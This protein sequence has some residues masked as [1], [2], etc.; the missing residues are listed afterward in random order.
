MSEQKILGLDL[1]S[2]SIGW[3]VLRASNK[4]PD[5]IIAAGSRIFNKAVEKKPPTLKNV[6]RRNKRL[7][8]RVLQRRARR[9]LKMMRY[10]IK[11]NLLP[12]DIL[13]SQQPEVILNDLGDPYHLR[14][15]GLDKKL[16][17]YE[18]GRVLLHLVQR[19]G[20]LSNR[21]TVLG[22]MIDDP[23]VLEILAGKDDDASNL[24][25]E[26][27][28][29]ETTF[30]A[31]IS[32]LKETIQNANCRT[33]G[34]YLASLSHH[35]SQRNRARDG[36]HLRTDRQM[37][38]E[39]L[40]LIWETQQQY[41]PALDDQV[42]KQ[43]EEII[44]T[45]R[46]LRLR[47]DRVGKCSLEHKNNRARMARLEAQKFRY[48][49]DINNLKFS[50]PQT[51]RERPLSLDDKARL[52]E[53]FETDLKVNL[54]KIKKIIGLGNRLK[55]NLESKNIKPNITAC[56]IR[57][58]LPEWDDFDELKQ[59]AL[60]EDLITF[61]KKSK[62][63]KRLINHWEFDINIATELCLLEFEPGHSNL[64]TKAIKKLLPFLKQGQIYSDARK[65]AGYGYET[66]ELEPTQRLG[67][68]RKTSNPI[69]NKALHE[70]RR[71]INAVIKE[72][73]KPDIIRIEMARDLEMNTKRYKRRISQQN[74]NKK[75]N[76]EAT[77]K[78]QQMA[79]MNPHLGLSHYP[80][81]TDKVRYR[82]WKDQNERCAYSG[83]A[84][85]LSTLFSSGEIEIDHIVPY[86]QSLDD[87]YMNKVVC[88]AREN[89]YKGQ[90]TPFDAFGGDEEK[91][92]QL[93]QA[94]E[95]WDERAL[96]SKKRRFYLTNED[97]LERDF[98]SSQ[99]NDTRY[100]SRR[101]L[102]YVSQLGADVNVTKG[103][104]VSQ[105]RWQWGL[106]SLI[107]KTHEKERTDHRHHA[108]DAIVIACVDRNFHK[109][110]TR[111]AR[112]AEK[113]ASELKVRDIPIPKPWK[114]LKQDAQKVIESI[115]VSHSP[116]RKITGG[117]H[118][119]TG[120]GFIEKLG[121]T[122]YR[123][124]LNGD[125]SSG[126]AKKIVDEN[127][128]EIITRHLAKYANDPK[129]A[130]AE[131]ITVFHKDGKTPIKRVRIVQ[132]KT[133]LKKL[134][135]SK[136]GVKNKRGEVFK[137]MAYGNIHHVEIIRNKLTGK[138]RGEFVTAME[139]SKRAKGIG[140]PKQNIVK[141]DHG[142]NFEFLMV[143]HT[144]DL[145]EINTNGGKQ[146]YRVQKISPGTNMVSF[147]LHTAANDNKL[148]G[149]DITV[150]NDFFDKRKISKLNLNAIGIKV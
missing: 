143:L 106:N 42:K 60:A 61:T 114:Q 107:G 29:E 72:Y 57:Q 103:I 24:S 80:S 85:N 15:K 87:S 147:R 30:K 12:E 150:N 109:Q 141:T 98:A 19:R 112:E 148:E 81:Q 132:S 117:L 88:Y 67:S 92:N 105:L 51:G 102:E 16:K 27:A 41:S 59:S 21:K 142:E 125:F 62:L 39:E 97:V 44:T 127:V 63:Q 144:N 9:K 31:D 95:R 20:F 64:S 130:F 3:A 26:Q 22:N 76:Q 94:V 96:K 104:L 129:K 134:E 138:I 69:V 34:E 54:T 55:L 7:G 56:K 82:L 36:G 136:F 75:A 131:N 6:K 135:Q 121:A 126:R 14:A 74:S 47:A 46:P 118:K 32:T 90:R 77:D 146:I 120:G 140:A 38:R 93:T 1:G 101:A 116:Q 124:D 139:A 73:G 23:D 40:R 13:N 4:K 53:L 78:Y 37:Y 119:E 108:I 84:I 145:V 79:E 8:R 71:I 58:V 18:L 28:K 45:Q 2:N 17:R 123:V 50:C 86:S 70:L 5:S 11:L 83:K 128:K 100:I 48:L 133:N 33:L 149:I 68:P 66:K 99:L 65:S 10:L 89:R 49:Q 111:S 115:I 113:Q 25:A 137:W 110:L 52:V 43:I 91:W 35:E 122:V